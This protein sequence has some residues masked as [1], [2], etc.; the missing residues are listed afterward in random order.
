MRFTKLTVLLGL[1]CCAASAT[2]SETPSLVVPASGVLGVQTEQLKAD[3]WVDRAPDGD[4]VLMDEKA[5]VAQ[6]QSVLHDDDSMYPLAEMP[7]TLQGS[8]VKAWIT[9]LS[10]RPSGNL[11]DI[12]GQRLGV[13]SINK[14]MDALALDAIAQRQKT[15][16]GLV[17][18][19]AALRRFPTDQRV[20]SE[21]GETDI[22]RFQES[23]IFPG[24]PVVIAHASRDGQ[25]LFV[26]SPRYAAWVHADAVAEG[27]REAV[28]AYP[29]RA[30]YRVITGDDVRTV[31][32]PEQPALSQLELDM[33]VRVPL[34][35]SVAADAPINGQ[36]TYTSWVLSLP[37]RDGKGRLQFAPAL[38]Q[39][40]ADTADD[41]L[42]L[43]RANILRQAFKFLGER[44]GWGHAYDGRDCSGF[45]SDVYKSMGVLMPRNTSDQSISPA[46]DHVK[47]DADSSDEER[48][49]AVANLDIG[50][51]VYIPGHVL[52]VIGKANGVHYVIH[53]VTG[54]S[55]RQA[56]GSM[57][58]VKLNSVSVTPLEP[59]MFNDHES[60][61]DR[62][63]S[64][65]HVHGRKPHEN[66]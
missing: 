41:Y 1:I 66:H 42:P 43:T 49:R 25:W 4:I 2:A 48:A 47:F 19:R 54:M 58:R 23:G 40:N 26:V 45:V 51:L 57:R 53:D 64:I 32:T 28:L 29:Q 65:V 24:T 31:F 22:D 21:P 52:M 5:I 56:D 20:F 38:V 59:L 33:G 18:H 50:D 46:L 55:Y 27:K 34:D 61:I 15:R 30:P 12:D 8:T 37:M 7:A 16:F 63:T 60:Y 13:T 10:S 3:Y 17:V 14:L 9:D 35:D 39:R 11:Y 6:N 44:Y 62:M 36:A